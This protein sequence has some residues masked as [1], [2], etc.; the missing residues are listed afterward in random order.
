MRYQYGSNAYKIEEVEQETVIKQPQEAPR[1]Q[2][3]ARVNKPLVVSVLCVSMLTISAAI[4]LTMVT[5]LMMAQLEVEALNQQLQTTKSKV[6]TLQSVITTNLD[7]DYIE[8]QAIEQLN[9][10]KPLPHQII[11]IDV[12]Q[13]NYTTYGK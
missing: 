3:R 4:Y 5:N 12:P 10:V 8:Q 13:E 2:T 7:L 9:M 1:Q 6:N 11:Y